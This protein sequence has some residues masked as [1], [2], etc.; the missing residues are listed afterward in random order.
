MTFPMTRFVRRSVY[1]KF[2][3]VREVTLPCPFRST[4]WRRGDNVYYKKREREKGRERRERERRG[5]EKAPGSS[6]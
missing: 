3:K 4:F 1:H 5:R 6:V 2:L